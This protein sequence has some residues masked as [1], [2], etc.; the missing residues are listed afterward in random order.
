M[1]SPPG[2][3]TDFES[4]TFIVSKYSQGLIK[5]TNGSKI[6]FMALGVL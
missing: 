1:S 3:S 2:S 6:V 5:I 4:V